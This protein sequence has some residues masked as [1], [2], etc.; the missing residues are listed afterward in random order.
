MFFILSK[1]LSFFLKPLG[2]IILLLILKYFIKNRTKK[3]RI[4]LLILVLLYFFSCPAI[5]DYFIRKWEIPFSQIEKVKP[6][7]FGILLTG[8]LVKEAQSIGSKVHI[9][10]QADRTWQA[11]ELYR[12]RKIKKILISGGDGFNRDLPEQLSEN[13]KAK[14]FLIRV[15]V[16]ER[17]IFQ[18]SYA[19]NTYENAKYCKTFMRKMRINA[20]NN[21]LITSG[22]HM[23]RALACFKKQNIKC[24]PFC[25][26]PETGS[27]K[28]TFLDFFPKAECLFETDQLFNEYIGMVVYK[29]MGYI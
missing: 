3:K 22:L 19:V 26:T 12:T 29:I 7:E 23:K 16:K 21:I 8:G 18:E 11:A 15:G 9:G 2:I 13:N 14:D 10:P 17:D 1:C 6:H 24:S 5:V 25:T 28:L 4:N 20:N 27:K